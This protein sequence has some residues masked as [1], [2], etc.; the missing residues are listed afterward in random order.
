MSTELHRYFDYQRGK[1]MLDRKQLWLSHIQCYND[2][3]EMLPA[4][5]HFDL[6]SKSIEEAQRE[7]GQMRK[8][9]EGQALLEKFEPPKVTNIWKKVGLIAAKGVL[10]PLLS[11][12]LAGIYTYDNYNFPDS[13]TEEWKRLLMYVQK[14]LP[15]L[16][17]VKGCCFS[18]T[19]DSVLM[20]TH[21]AD[22]NNGLVVTFNTAKEFWKEEHFQPITYTNERIQLPDENTDENKYV[23]DILTRKSTDWKYEKEWRLISFSMRNQNYLNIDPRVV[24]AIY[25]GLNVTNA[26][27]KNIL[28]IQKAKYPHA[29]VFRMKRNNSNYK[30][31][32]EQI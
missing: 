18:T 31:E 9:S 3:F 1:E 22:W 2:P 17:Q 26:Q 25:L 32:Y 15:L 21:Y 8:T 16:M 20:W 11:I 7:L 23:W 6:L 4:T 12:L 19:P 5:K 29:K 14:Y 24:T 28:K 10:D 27:Q 30:L 13:K